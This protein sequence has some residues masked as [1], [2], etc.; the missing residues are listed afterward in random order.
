MIYN[1]LKYSYDKVE[2]RGE[3]GG[4]RCSWEEEGVGEELGG[5]GSRGGDW[6]V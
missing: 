1:Q 3:L 4:G 2:G 5:E 6:R